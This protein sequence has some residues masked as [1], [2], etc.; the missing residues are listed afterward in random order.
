[1]PVSKLISKSYADTI[2]NSISTKNI[3]AVDTLHPELLDTSESMETTHFSVIDKEGNMVSCTY[4]LNFAFGN[5]M[6]AGKTGIILNNEMD[7][8]VAKPGSQWIWIT[9]K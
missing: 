5:G 9:G 7:D 3:I 6:I 4:T 8:F 1:M 2:A